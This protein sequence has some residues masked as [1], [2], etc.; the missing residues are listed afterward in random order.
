MADASR[1]IKPDGVLAVIGMNPHAEKDRWFIYDYFPGT[2]EADLQRYPSPEIIEKWMASVCFGKIAHK[3][4]ECLQNDRNSDNVFPLS[5][6]FTSQ[7]SLLS[8]ED[9]ERGISR[10]KAVLLEAKENEREV[11]F[12]VDISLAM[13]TGWSMKQSSGKKSS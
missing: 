11:I 10:I 3:I 12:P 9:Y 13:V 5:K 7:L 4:A 8:E 2:H 1:V 6:E